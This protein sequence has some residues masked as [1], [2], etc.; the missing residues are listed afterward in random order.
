[1]DGSDYEDEDYGSGSGYEDYQ[2]G[3]SGQTAFTQ[4]DAKITI[5]NGV[6]TEVLRMA[7]D[8]ITFPNEYEKFI[9]S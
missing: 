5:T 2:C 4:S 6:E 1:M 3:G 7:A 8:S 9:E